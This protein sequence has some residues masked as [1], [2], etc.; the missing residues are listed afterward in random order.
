MYDDSQPT[1]KLGKTIPIIEDRR[2]TNLFKHVERVPTLTYVILLILIE[3]IAFYSVNGGTLHPELEQYIPHYLSDRPILQKIYS[4]DQVE[5]GSEYRP[6]PL[7]YLIDNYDVLFIGW[8]TGLGHPHFESLS[9]FVFWTIDC[10][11]CWFCFRNYFGLDRL[12]TAML[13][14]LF[15]TSPVV[16][17]SCSYFRSAKPGA[18]CLMLIAFLLVRRT[19]TPEASTSFCPG[20]IAIDTAV[21]FTVLAACLFDE[22]PAAFALASLVMLAFE[23]YVGDNTVRRKA[24][25]CIIPIGSALLIFAIYDVFLHR[26]LIKHF[27]GHESSTQ[28]QSG[29]LSALIVRPVVHFL[30]TVSVLTEVVGFLIGGVSSALGLVMLLFLLKVW[31]LSSGRIQI[32]R[33][34]L[35]TTLLFGILFVMISRHPALMSFTVRRGLY[36]LPFMVVLLIFVALSTDLIIRKHVLS[37]SVTALILG[38]MVVSNVTC[39]VRVLPSSA[40]KSDPNKEYSQAMKVALRFGKGITTDMKVGP[41]GEYFRRVEASPIYNSLHQ[42]VVRRRSNSGR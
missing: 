26:V 40:D 41:T 21:F 29:L 4:A 27:T 6:R 30:G 19:Y 16:F 1:P 10:F 35:A 22:V 7:S 33:I 31:Q 37:K 25:R 11:L 34:Q 8:C 18:V 42:V 13:I 32:I 17:F 38:T 28:Y 14:G 20:R 15:C 23:A 39:L 24:V 2:F 9:Y 36:V 3:I 5:I 12:N